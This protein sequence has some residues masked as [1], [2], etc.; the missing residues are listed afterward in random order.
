MSLWTWFS[1]FLQLMLDYCHILSLAVLCNLLHLIYYQMLL[2]ECNLVHHTEE[3]KTMMDQLDCSLCFMSESWDRDSLGL[4]S[5]IHMDG[6]KIIKNVLQRKGK[7][8]KPALIIKERDYFIKELC[9]DIITVPPGVEAVWALL[10]PKAGG[11]KANIRHIAVCS[12]YYTLKTKRSDFIDHIS[13][14]YNVLL[15]FFKFIKSVSWLCC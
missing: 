9:P 12:Y 11:S 4:E 7:G 1:F 13:E 2:S 5:V 10:T 3:F 6:F 15:F 8:G 14:A